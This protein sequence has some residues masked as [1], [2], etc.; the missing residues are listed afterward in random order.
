MS[1][2]NI[3]FILADQLR[4]DFL[5][6][7]GAGFVD[8]PNIDAIASN[9]VAYDMAYSPTPVC[10]PA[11]ASL[12][13]GRDSI[14]NG[15]LDNENWLRDDLG[16]CG[17]KTWPEILSDNGYFTAAI[18]KMHFYPWDRHHGFAYRVIA[19]DKRWIK[20][21]DDYYRFLRERGERKYHGNEHE[22][23]YEN[24]GA[25]ISRLPIEYSV[26]RFVGNEAVKFI[27]TYGNE[28]PFALMVGFPGPHCPYD[29]CA[30]SLVRVRREEIPAPIPYETTAGNLLAGQI[31]GNKMPWNG[32]D[33]SEFTLDQQMKC[34][35]HYAALVAQIDDEV[36]AILRSLRRNNLSDNTVVIFSSDHGDLLGDHGLIAKGNYYEG[37]SHIPLLVSLPGMAGSKR[38]KKLVSLCDVTAT[39]TALAGL[40]QPGYYD[41]A[42]LPGLGLSR[43][44]R[45]FIFGF[46]SGS[47]FATDGRFKLTKF[48]NG[49]IH[50]FDLRTDPSELMN[51]YDK[52][53]YMDKFKELDGKLTTRVMESIIGSNSDKVVDAGTAL[54][55]S[56]NYGKQGVPRAYP[57]AR[58]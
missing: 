18:G 17:I 33:L 19:E 9:G 1:A 43:D 55:N 57:A 51:L 14:K 28:G 54:W 31:A 3:V 21:R 8:T 53:D 27:D 26:D 32:V 40:K 29:P 45:D 22:N 6:C 37:S 42:P 15:V 11:R 38:E 35:E 58:K 56:D 39:I 41:C 20:V 30:E 12:L 48:K 47:W 36:G 44:D 7:Y 25:I 49:D 2:P 10:V 52:P 50:L 24:K 4:H 34:R 46:M 16:L 23:Y 13:T 5:C